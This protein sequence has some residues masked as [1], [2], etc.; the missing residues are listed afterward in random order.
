MFSGGALNATLTLLT[1]LV[2]SGMKG[3]GFKDLFQ[4]TLF[5]HNLIVGTISF[6]SSS[7][8][9]KLYLIVLVISIFRC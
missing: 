4:V 2:M 6:I 9:L 7:Y 3:M 8:L 1:E 5:C